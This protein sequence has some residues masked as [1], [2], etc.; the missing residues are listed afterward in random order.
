MIIILSLIIIAF[1]ITLLSSYTDIK[2]RIAPDYLSY[3]LMI[4]GVFGNLLLSLTTNNFTYIFYSVVFLVGVLILS[5]ILSYVGFWGMG[6]T[7][8]L[9]GYAACFPVTFSLFNLP[10]YP[11]TWPFFITIWLNSLLIGP[12]LAI[13]FILWRIWKNRDE[14]IPAIRNQI[15]KSLEIKIPFKKDKLKINISIILSMLLV[16]SLLFY[17]ID[18]NFGLYILISWAFITLFYYLFNLA[19]VTDSNIYS[20]KKP[21]ELIEGDIPIDLKINLPKKIKKYGLT[22]EQIKFIQKNY[23]KQIKIKEGFPFI[24]SFMVSFIVSIFFGDI[25]FNLINSILR[26]I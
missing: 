20:L 25:L 5:S 10:L 3:A 19:R 6:D 11:A 24:I 13:F 15:R 17:F 7:K 18:T 9:A 23:K 8:I 14:M 4:F 16:F 12:L 21:N 22:K 26:N 1:I 2:W